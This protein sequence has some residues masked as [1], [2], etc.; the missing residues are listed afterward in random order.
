[1][2]DRDKFEE[3]WMRLTDE[4]EAAA[5]DAKMPHGPLREGLTFVRHARKV[6]VSRP[7]SSK[8]VEIGFDR[9]A[10]GEVIAIIVE[11]SGQPIEKRYPIEGKPPRELA[12]ELIRPLM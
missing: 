12:M 4:I 6:T 3:L 2:V 5:E 8:R 11:T 1:M 10:D 9:A 7:G